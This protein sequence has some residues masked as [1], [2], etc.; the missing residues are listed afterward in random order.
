MKM[1]LLFVVW[2][3]IFC[4]ATGNAQPMEWSITAKVLAM[5][6]GLSVINSSK[7]DKY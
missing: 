1:L 5:I 6:V 2:Y 4:F 3:G 7:E